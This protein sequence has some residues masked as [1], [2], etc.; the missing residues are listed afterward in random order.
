MQRDR[1][2]KA[3]Y[4]RLTALCEQNNVKPCTCEHWENCCFWITQRFGHK[5]DLFKLAKNIV[6]TP[7]YGWNQIFKK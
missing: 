7:G 1:F 3:G 6:N 2:L 5:A 4:A